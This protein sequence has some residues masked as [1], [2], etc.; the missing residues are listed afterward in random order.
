MDIEKDEALLNQFVAKHLKLHRE[1]KGITQSQMAR[2]LGV[3]IFVIQN[4]ELGV[5]RIPAR[6]LYEACQVFEISLRGFF[7]D[8]TDAREAEQPIETPLDFPKE[9]RVG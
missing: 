4:A 2:L 7:R 3:N 8:Y 5:E 9:Q 6:S 1:R